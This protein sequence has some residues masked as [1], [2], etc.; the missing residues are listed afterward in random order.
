MRNAKTTLVRMGAVL[1]LAVAGAA[2]AGTRSDA[3]ARCRELGQAGTT[4]DVP[5]LAEALRRPATAETAR[6]ALERVPGEA[7]LAALREGLGVL[8]GR[9]LVGAVN[10]LGAR[11]D[12]RAIDAL[13]VL[14]TADDAEVRRAA[15]EALGRIG[16][17]GTGR[18]LLGVERNL[19]AD[20]RP[21]V[22]HALL[23]CALGLRDEGLAEEATAILETLLD[24]RHPRAVRIAAFLARTAAADPRDDDLLARVLRGDDAV[25]L[26]AAQRHLAQPAHRAQLF[27]LADRLAELPPVVQTQ[28]VLLVTDDREV[29]EDVLERLAAGAR[30]EG[31]QRLALTTLLERRAAR[32]PNLAR[33]ATA[34]SPDGVDPDHDGREAEAAIDGNPATYWDETDGRPLYRLLVTFPAPRAISAFAVQG[35]AHH[36]FSPRHFEVRL[37]GELVGRVRDASYVRNRLWVPLPPTTCETVELWITGAYGGSPAVREL[38]I[39]DVA[40]LAV[41]LSVFAAGDPSA[42]DDAS[43]RGLI[44]DEEYEAILAAAPANPRV[45]PRAPRRVLVYSRCFGY[46][47]TSIPYGKAAFA[48]MGAKSGAYEV[49]IRDDLEV[50]EADELRRF[51]AIVFNSTNEEIFLPEDFAALP[52]AEQRAAAEVD[53]RLKANLLDF[54]ASG[55]GLAVIHA[56]VA[57][58]RAWPEFGNLMGA[59]FENHPWVAG[60]TVAL[61]VDDP[62]HPVAAALRNGA[63]EAITDEIYQLADPFSRDD[64]RVLL[65]VDLAKS[66]VT[67]EVEAAFRRADRDFPL[68][69]VRKYGRGRV[70]YSAL[71][72]QHDIYWNA[73]VLQHWLDGVQF[74]LGDLDGDTTPSNRVASAAAPEFRWQRTAQSFALRNRDAVVWQLNRDWDI[75]KAY[76]HPVALTDGTELTWLSPPDHVWH[77][78]LWFEWKFIDG[79]NYWEEVPDKGLTEIVEMNSDL[80][81]DFSAHFR[82]TI[83]Y[84]PPDGAPV[85]REERHI[86]VSPPDDAG[87]YRI[88]WTGTFTALE[89]DLVLDRTPPEGEPDGVSWGGY[90]GMSARIAQ[91]TTG[92][93]IT[94]S[95]GREGMDCHRQPARWIHADFARTDTGREGGIGIFDAP[96]N[97]RHPAPSFIVLT[98]AQPFVYYSPAVLFDGALTL[99]HGTPLTLRYRIL[100]HPDRATPEM[101]EQEWNRFSSDLDPSSPASD[102]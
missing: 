52:A 50:F 99:P 8:E 31:A 71:G 98:E 49:E 32:L 77:R 44:P 21:R 73:T 36:N 2:Q 6:Q 53:A 87:R 14:V 24:A 92:W 23:A 40:D 59:R 16:G 78:A 11:R 13:L 65:S 35:W 62:A 66:K 9:A 83:D 93:H 42:D 58:F 81:P 102:R 17:S 76:F 33:G 1:L 67:A 101:L 60:S 80:R 64:A 7:S 38:E 96:E 34:T 30:D 18:V 97:V 100:V 19:P 12:R 89:R 70:F 22:A 47:H 45:A 79:V 15:V 94:D 28:V 29:G 95:E 61:K 48:L 4:T 43:A 41:P 88:D 90:A 39:Y 55:K 68:S 46:V 69:Y 82:M 72:H 27:A 86:V 37:D 3:G 51:D 26:Q 75:G 91:Q 54:V 20:E 63:L 56:G 57:T 85:M 25:L 74:V 10:S 84:H 5:E